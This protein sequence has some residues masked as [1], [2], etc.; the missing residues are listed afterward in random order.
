MW[1]EWTSIVSPSLWQVIWRIFTVRNISN[2]WFTNWQF[3]YKHL[4][5]KNSP[6]VLKAT[7]Q[8]A[9]FLPVQLRVF[10]FLILMDCRH[11]CFLHHHSCAHFCLPYSS[12]LLPKS[13]HDCTKAKV[14]VFLS[15]KLELRTSLIYIWYKWLLEFMLPWTL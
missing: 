3:T 13:S 2:F 10:S 9:W 14:D 7:V 8:V 5:N 12:S 1:S 15:L 4:L 6:L 11:V